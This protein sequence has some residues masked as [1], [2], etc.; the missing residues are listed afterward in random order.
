MICL[1]DDMTVGYRVAGNQISSTVSEL[2]MLTRK[3]E[4]GGHRVRVHEIPMII[5]G[6]VAAC[7]DKRAEL[8]RTADCTTSKPRVI[9]EM[10][11][12]KTLLVQLVSGGEIELSEELYKLKSKLNSSA[13][14]IAEQYSLQQN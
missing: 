8:L 10:G 1:D 14:T 9:F 12:R 5:S 6:H 13:I 3:Y 7:L 2:D 11:Y 4:Y